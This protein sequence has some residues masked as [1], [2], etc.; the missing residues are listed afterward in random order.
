MALKKIL[1]RNDD[2]V[3]ADMIRNEVK[4]WKSL[5][6]HPNIVELYD[7]RTVEEDGGKFVIVLMELCPD[8]HLLDLLE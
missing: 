5:G 6:K 7:Y 1:I 8:G 4:V 2:H 3:F